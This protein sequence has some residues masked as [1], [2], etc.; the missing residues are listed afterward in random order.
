MCHVPEI[1]AKDATTVPEIETKDDITVREIEAKDG[2]TVTYLEEYMEGDDY[3]MSFDGNVKDSLVIDL[4]GEDDTAPK[5]NS[6]AGGD[7]KGKKI[8]S[9]CDEDMKITGD[10]SNAAIIHGDGKITFCRLSTCF[11]L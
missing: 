2:T 10:V 4:C 5:K 9:G 8:S 3:S 11:V 7:I 6:S 1:E